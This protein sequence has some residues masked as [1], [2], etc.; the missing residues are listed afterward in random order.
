V[1][2]LDVSREWAERAWYRRYVLLDDGSVWVWYY[3]ADA[4]T[5][6]LALSVGPTCGLTLAVVIVLA[7]WLAFGV[8]ALVRRRKARDSA[9]RQ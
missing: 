3:D 5:S 7:I 8:W 6:L 9:K 2:A 1:E 4:N